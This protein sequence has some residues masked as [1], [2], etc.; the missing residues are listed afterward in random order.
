MS[1]LSPIEIKNET[2]SKIQ[3]KF[4]SVGKI[5]KL[6]KV[7]NPEDKISNFKQFS[8]GNQIEFEVFHGTKQKYVKSVLKYG[9]LLELNKASSKGIGTYFS[10]NISK[11]HTYTDYGT[12][13]GKFMFLCDIV[14]EP[15]TNIINGGVEIIINND[16][17]ILIRY[18]ICY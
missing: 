3:K 10:K 7:V 2:F 12:S 13:I 9:F 15:T 17:A 11:S 8:E 18:L 4:N 14:I 5:K 16:D 6:F 1:K